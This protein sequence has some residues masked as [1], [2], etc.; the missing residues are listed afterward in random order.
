MERRKLHWNGCLC[1]MEGGIARLLYCIV[2]F[3][4][5]QVK[6]SR[7]IKHA[8][9]LKEALTREAHQIFLASFRKILLHRA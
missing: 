7:N 5:N 8:L 3:F 9:N 4:R 1:G 2:E 6:P